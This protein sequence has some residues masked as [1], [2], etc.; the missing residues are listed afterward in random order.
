MI[1]DLFRS[2]VARGTT[3]PLT[4]AAVL[5]TSY[6]TIEYA[7]A[8]GFAAVSLISNLFLLVIYADLGLGAAVINIV[9]ERRD[10]ASRNAQISTI[11][12][13]LAL[14]AVLLGVLGIAGNTFFSWAS[15]LGIEHASADD[16]DTVT[17]TVF[18]IFAATLP[19][20]VGQRVL[21]GLKLNHV[22]I[23]LSAVSSFAT[24]A[25]TY[26]SVSVGLP[27]LWLSVGQAAGLFIAALVCS[28][29]AFHKLGLNLL[30]ILRAKMTPLRPFFSHAAPMLVIMIGLPVAFQSHRLILAHSSSISELAEYSLALQFYNPLW[31]FF[32]VGAMSLWP[33]FAE[34]RGQRDAH[35]DLGNLFLV[36]GGCAVLAGIGMVL[37]G[38][39]AGLLLSKSH[40]VLDAGIL[41]AFS[42]LLL[43]QAIQQVPGMYF[44]DPRGLR[45]QSVC[46][47]AMCIVAVGGS[48]LT[49]PSL[50]AVGPV[51]STAMAVACCQVIPGITRIRRVRSARF[52]S[53]AETGNS[54]PR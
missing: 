17:M 5:L 36:L 49:T 54:L 9:A 25:I 18:L 1:R 33:A 20:G 16:V 41:V 45:F 19:L 15:V 11:F 24:L 28:W 31:S 42:C 10:T 6:M 38:Q 4:A 52:A 40:I 14:P 2:V 26:V 23:V 3:F 46:V 35:V 32:S 8:D 44:T 37:L 47:T 21:T 13:L 39:P 43:V 30:G 51:A 29:I 27:F 22:G 12:R 50:G 7:G 34:S 48:V 53:T